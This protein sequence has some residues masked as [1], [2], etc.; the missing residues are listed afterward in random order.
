MADGAPQRCD[1]RARS[2]ILH[3]IYPQSDRKLVQEL[4]RFC[5]LLDEVT[6]RSRSSYPMVPKFEQEEVGM[7]WRYN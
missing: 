4:V 7:F 6:G 1:L 5:S 3:E 2:L